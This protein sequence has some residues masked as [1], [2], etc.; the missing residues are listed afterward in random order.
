LRSLGINPASASALLL[1]CLLWS[2]TPLRSDLLPGSVSPADSASLMNQATILALFAVLALSAALV[3][4]A[5]WPRGHLLLQA[6]LAGAGLFALPAFTIDLARNYIDEATHVAL[7]SLVPVFAVVFEPHLGDSSQAPPQG[8]SLVAA[9]T[10]VAGTLLVF[11]V[12]LPHTVASILAFVSIMMA[13]AV[14][15]ASNCIAV[16]LAHNPPAVPL[17]VLAAVSI[18]TAAIVL[19]ISSVLIESHLWSALHPDPW[20]ITDLL[21][22]ALLFWLMPRIYALRAT[23]RFLIAPL[24]ANLVA[25]AFLRPGVQARAWLGL[26]LIALGSAWLLFAHDDE[27]DQTGSPLGIN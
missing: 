4:K 17:A 11:P 14:L 22:L 12:E 5:N 18:G 20:A 10:A 8:G 15:A 23:T 27:R 19:A 21:A 24:L 16:K 26:T 6:I 25:L 1:L 9:L 2:A 7:F 3:R 13:A